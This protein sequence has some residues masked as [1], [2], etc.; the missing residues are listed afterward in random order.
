MSRAPYGSPKWLKQT[1]ARASLYWSQ[2]DVARAYL[3]DYRKAKTEEGTCRRCPKIAEPSR[4]LCK[5]CGKRDRKAAR[6]RM[7]KLRALRR[8][9]DRAYV[10]LDAIVDLARVRVLRLTRRLDW[11]SSYELNELLGNV[12]EKQRN[13]GAQL[14][15]RLTKAG[16]FERRD[17]DG[18]LE[19]LR[20][21]GS[22]LEYRITAAGIAEVDAILSGKNRRVLGATKRAA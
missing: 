21:V 4:T 3:V 9:E 18:R 22:T 15:G 1:H 20:G 5:A 14:L 8:R 11:F 10:P 6:K 19:G 17:G 12:D 2:P 13:T 16:L 7:R